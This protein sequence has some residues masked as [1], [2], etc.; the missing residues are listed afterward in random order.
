MA[1]ERRLDE[2]VQGSNQEVVAAYHA[3]KGVNDLLGHVRR[4]PCSRDWLDR[5]NSVPSNHPSLVSLCCILCSIMVLRVCLHFNHRTAE[6]LDD[7]RRRSLEGK[8]QL[9]APS[10]LIKLDRGRAQ[11]DGT[12]RWWIRGKRRFELRCCG[13]SRRAEGERCWGGGEIRLSWRRQAARGGN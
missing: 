8:Q 5:V 10:E 13:R 1:A 3:P 12:R 11:R 4:N 9:G 2:D 7:R 6:L